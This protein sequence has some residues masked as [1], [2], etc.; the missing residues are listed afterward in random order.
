AASMALASTSTGSPF[1][2]PST[3]TSASSAAASARSA[4]DGCDA[5][6]FLASA[7]AL[8]AASTDESLTVSSGVF[9]SGTVSPRSCACAAPAASTTA[10]PSAVIRFRI[11]ISSLR[12]GYRGSCKPYAGIALPPQR[13]DG[14]VPYAHGPVAQL[15]RAGDSSKR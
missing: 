3:I 5:C 6:S 4:A 14:G 2:S 11:S 10:M 12:D 8:T 15:V 13:N 9:G 7:A 1:L